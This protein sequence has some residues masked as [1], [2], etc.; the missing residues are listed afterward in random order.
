MNTSLI[1]CENVRSLRG[2]SSSQTEYLNYDISIEKSLT[3]QIEYGD[4]SETITHD[5]SYACGV[6]M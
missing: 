4:V 2:G 6:N 5:C 1:D 3:M